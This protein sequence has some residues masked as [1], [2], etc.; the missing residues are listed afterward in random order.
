MIHRA[1]KPPRDFRRRVLGGQLMG[2]APFNLRA[3]A[4]KWRRC[5]GMGTLEARYGE[6]FVTLTNTQYEIR[7]K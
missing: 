6:Y 2:E 7:N 5:A 3:T 4:S 1:L